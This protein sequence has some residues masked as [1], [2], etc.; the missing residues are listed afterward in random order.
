[1]LINATLYSNNSNFELLPSRS[2]RSS[3]MSKRISNIF[4]SVYLAVIIFQCYTFF[5]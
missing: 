2:S 5:F 3:K 4:S 1:M